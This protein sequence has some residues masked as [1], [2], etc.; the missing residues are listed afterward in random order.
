MGFPLVGDKLYGLD[1]GCFLR[2]AEGKIDKEDLMRL[3]LPNQ[4]LHCT[5]LSFSNEAGRVIR[6]SSAP[7]W[8]LL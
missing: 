5:Q 4:A 6:A 2:F 8:K 3:M 1:E 7:R